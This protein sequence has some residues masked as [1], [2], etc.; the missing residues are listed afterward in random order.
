VD[1][2]RLDI[3]AAADIVPAHVDIVPAG[4]QVMPA[5]VAEPGEDRADYS[6]AQTE[7]KQDPVYGY[8]II[9]YGAIHNRSLLNH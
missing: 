7:E 3:V 4:A 2:A 1:P 9:R 8:G 5:E 6:E